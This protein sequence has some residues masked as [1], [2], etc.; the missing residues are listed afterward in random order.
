M[1]L[2]IALVGILLGMTTVGL[3]STADREGA[4]G[5]AYALA[6]EMRSAR[7]EAQRSGKY[8]AVCFPS[9]G[10][11]IP[12]SRSAVLRRGEQKG[13]VWRT[14]NFDS[15]FD[16]TIFAGKWSDDPIAGD[17]ALPPAWETSTR[18][19]IAIFF[20]PDGTAFSNDLRPRDSEL[21]IVVAS[22]YVAGSGTG[23][24]STLTGAASP[25]T[26]WVSSSGTVRVET[27][28]V[29]GGVLPVG[30]STVRIAKLNLRAGSSSAPEIRSAVLHPKPIDT[31]EGAGVSQSFVQIHPFQKD[32][33][34]LEYGLVTIEVEAT[35]SDGGPLSYTLTAD[36]IGGSG[37]GGAFSVPDLKGKMRFV[38]DPRSRQHRWKATVSWR[39]PPG[40]PAKTSYNLTL[41]VTDPEGNEAI[42]STET[43]LLP[44]IVSLPP[45][46]IVMSTAGGKLYL[47]NLDGGGHTLITRDGDEFLP[48]FSRD[49]SRVFSFHSVSAG[50]HELRSRAANG[51]TS[52]DALA[53]FTGDPS[54][55]WTDPTSCYAV[56]LGGSRTVNFPWA[57]AV[58]VSGGG[59]DG[60]P[61]YRLQPGSTPADM[62]SLFIVNLMT[63]RQIEVADNAVEN[64]FDW[65]SNRNGFFRYREVVANEPR[66]LPGG[67]GSHPPRPGS[68]QEDA[69]KFLAWDP[70]T[71]VR[72]S[73]PIE[74][75]KDRRYNPADSNWYA[76]VDGT[77]LVVRNQTTG[78]TIT[79]ASGS[80]E[81]ARFGQNNPTWSAN[82]QQLAFI[83]SPGSG[84]L[85]RAFRIFNDTGA[86]LARAEET[87]SL[88]RP[89]ATLAQLDPE[90]EWIYF[91][92]NSHIYRGS[93]VNRRR[94]PVEISDDIRPGG[95]KASM[96]SYVVSP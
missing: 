94:A 51:T 92:Q 43:E 60:P 21:P 18:D 40:A 65:A 50:S 31:E 69:T 59:D 54:D 33:D 87:Y 38:H 66:P 76:I 44:K 7:S 81:K 82:G 55:V 86:P 56:L 80:F 93:I 64:S 49:G 47:T 70:F 75:A 16:A 85:V 34:Q 36:V 9:G 57:I 91:L 1:V 96:Q 58:L 30:E 14:L 29:P 68:H 62:H 74:S 35:D 8:V 20:R 17:S 83:Q 22:G 26:I 13:D 95:V 77:D 32:G 90:G 15:E 89:N 67:L 45:A 10:K 46:R 71:A 5:L 37:N 63:G 52:F 79:I 24:E 19:E 28:T 88:A 53:N 12:F 3:R 84:A 48:F 25:Q 23:A 72:T 2:A 73:L 6:S 61:V 42:A 11:T 4:R 41:R 27:N 39:P 78:Q